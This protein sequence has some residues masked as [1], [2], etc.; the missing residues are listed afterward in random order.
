MT[1]EPQRPSVPAARPL[2]SGRLRSIGVVV[3]TLTLGPQIGLVKQAGPTIAAIRRRAALRV[4][5][6]R[7]RCTARHGAARERRTAEAPGLPRESGTRPR[8]RRRSRDLARRARP[9]AAA[10][11]AANRRV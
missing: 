1:V 9:S 4:V 3:T 7:R 6:T 5:G 11:G 2:P 10:T 8:T